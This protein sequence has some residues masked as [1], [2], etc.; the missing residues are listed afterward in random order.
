M[1]YVLAAHPEQTGVGN[2]DASIARATREVQEVAP[3]FAPVS[4]SELDPDRSNVVGVE[5]VVDDFVV[6]A[7]ALDCKLYVLEPAVPHRDP[8]SF[9]VNCHGSRVRPD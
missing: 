3:D 2:L 4:G 1:N 9:G 8:V 6:R 5:V 7:V